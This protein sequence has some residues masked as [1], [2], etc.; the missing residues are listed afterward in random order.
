VQPVQFT[1]PTSDRV[2]RFSEPATFECK[3]SKPDARA[4]WLNDGLDLQHGPEYD[5]GVRS[6]HAHCPAP[7][8]ATATMLLP[9]E[10]TVTAWLLAAYTVTS[11]PPDSAL[12]R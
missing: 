12:T 9:G 11:S 6:C 8:Q 10:V 7:F 4:H 5:I 1:R 2:S 3:V